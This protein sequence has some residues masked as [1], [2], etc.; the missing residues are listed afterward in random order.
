M[1]CSSRTYR[2][3]WHKLNTIA[4]RTRC[5]LGLLQRCQQNVQTN[6]KTGSKTKIKNHTYQFCFQNVIC[7]GCLC[8]STSKWHAWFASRCLGRRLST[9]QMTVASC[10]I[11]LGALYRQLTFR[12]AWCCEHSAV[13]ATELLQPLDL[14]CGTLF[15]SSCAIHTS[16]M[17]CSGD[18]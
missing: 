2:F 10:L 18:S 8:A 13:M 1:W 5:I 16:L 11:A 17:H 9:W 12:L 6:T 15:R 14:T 4:S 3:T 7:S